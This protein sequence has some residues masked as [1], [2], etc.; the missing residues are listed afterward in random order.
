MAGVAA[1]S[2]AARAGGRAV[3]GAERT[4]AYFDSAF[5]R[6]RIMA[7]LRGYDP[8][9]TVELCDRAWSIGIEVVE[10]PIQT[11]EA[12]KSLRAAVAAARERGLDVGGGTVVT[13]DQVAVAAEAGAAF[14]V[15]PG[16][17]ERIAAASLAHEM[18]HVPG[19]ASA[20]DI[21]SALRLGLRWLKAFP[22]RELGAGWLAAMHGPFPDVRFLATGGMDAT[23]AGE[24]LAAGAR[25]VAVGSALSAD[26]QLDRLAQL[27]RMPP[28][29]GAER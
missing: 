25:V 19:V 24:F 29:P 5:A 21:Q 9:R 14:T 17:D 23:N 22:A 2:R 6:H 13:T 20:S 3:T 28:E 26:G 4:G 10:V 16:F 1:A 15:A 11:P 18:P 8:A 12:V 27:D 7:I